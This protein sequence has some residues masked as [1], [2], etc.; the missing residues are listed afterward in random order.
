MMSALV[1]LLRSPAGKVVII[2]AKL[3][4]SAAILYWLWPKITTPVKWGSLWDGD[5]GLISLCIAIEM[6]KLLVLA[7]RWRIVTIAVATGVEQVPAFWRFFSFTWISMA[8]SQ[9]FPAMIGGDGY[10]IATLRMENLSLS[11]AGKSVVLDRIIGFV[12]LAAIIAAVPL[13]N[14]ATRQS[15][16]LLMTLSGILAT[17][18]LVLYLGYQTIQVRLATLMNWAGAPNVGLFFLVLALAVLGHLLSV[19]TFCIMAKAYAIEMPLGVALA[20]FPAALLMAMVPIA[21][22]GW[23]AREAAVVYS[24]PLHGVSGEAGLLASVL[25]GIVQS[26]V[27]LP[28]VALLFWGQKRVNS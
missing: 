28:S 24:L 25:F 5:I 3:F 19:A 21:F 16:L 7:V 27:A 11:N 15:P 13:V 9:V 6:V 18:G 26:L 17:I 4:V 12:G 2:L 20:V 23:G 14:W 22:G 8:I 1:S 10:R